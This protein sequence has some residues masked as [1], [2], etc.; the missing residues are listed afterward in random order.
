MG[1]KNASFIFDYRVVAQ[2]GEV[3]IKYVITHIY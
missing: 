2:N 1:E 3:R